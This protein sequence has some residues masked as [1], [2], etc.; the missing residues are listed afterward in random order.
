MDC[1]VFCLFSHSHNWLFGN[2]HQQLLCPNAAESP[3]AL[4]PP[5][6]LDIETALQIQD[7]FPYPI[8]TSSILGP[9]AIVIFVIRKKTIPWRVW[10]PRGGLAKDHKKYVF[11]RTPSLSTP[12]PHHD[13]HQ[14]MRIKWRSG[15]LTVISQC[16][17]RP[18]LKPSQFNSRQLCYPCAPYW[19]IF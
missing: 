4:F 8:N 10:G 13:I 7:G 9:F 17:W 6:T 11:F 16:K 3:P 2:N 1:S 19:N 14:L 15:G 5:H 12:C 18:G